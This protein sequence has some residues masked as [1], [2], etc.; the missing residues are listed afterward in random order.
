MHASKPTRPAPPSP[1]RHG[2]VR[3]A[4]RANR[5]ANADPPPP[6][7]AA[8]RPGHAPARAARRRALPLTG[9]PP[10]AAIRHRH[11][12]ARA[13]GGGRARLPA[14]AASPRAPATAVR[15]SADS[16]TPP[17]CRAPQDP[18]L[19]G[20]QQDGRQRQRQPVALVHLPVAG[21]RRHRGLEPS[22]CLYLAR[23][24]VLA[25]DVVVMPATEPREDNQTGLWIRL[26][27]I[28]RNARTA[29]CRIGIAAKLQ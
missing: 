13:R 14:T 11:S 17:S 22:Y 3:P 26:G 10:T 28:G 25:P 18:S 9:W 12:A 24:V 4:L 1:C 2:A 19:C 21:G 15:A 8:P 27:R 29:P 16:P 7:P 20:D 23:V 6:A 5:A